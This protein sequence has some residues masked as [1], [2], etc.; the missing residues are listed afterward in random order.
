MK[1]IKILSMK[2]EVD[3]I[4]P[5]ANLMITHTLLQ[6]VFNE[7]NMSNSIIYYS[8]RSQIYNILKKMKLNMNDIVILHTGPLWK[9]F[10]YKRL[11]N[12]INS[13]FI[14]Y[15]SEPIHVR[16]W[17]WHKQILNHPK[18]LMIWDYQYLSI[19]N[20]KKQFNNCFFVPP[21]YDI[22]LENMIPKN[23]WNKK[24][25]DILFYGDLSS[26]RKKIRN[27]LKKKNLNIMF[28]KFTNWNTQCKYISR[29]K[30]VL[31]IHHQINYKCIDYYRINYLIANKVFII[32]EDVQKEE[33]N[34][35][36]YKKLVISK[37]ENI[38]DTC[39]EWL[40]KTQ[41]ERDVFSNGLYNFF[42][43]ELPLKNFIPKQLVELC[44]DN[45]IQK[46]PL[47]KFRS[48]QLVDIYPNQQKNI[49][50]YNIIPKPKKINIAN[51]YF[52]IS[53]NNKFIISI[54][55]IREFKDYLLEKINKF[56]E[57]DNIVENTIKLILEKDTSISNNHKIIIEK[58][59]ITINGNSRVAIFHG[60]QSFIQLFS[61]YNIP[62]GII[63]DNDSL[64]QW[65][66]MH[67]DICRHYYGKK[68][69]FDYI[70]KLALFKFN[71]F[72][73]HLTEDQGWRIEIK[74]YPLLNSIGSWRNGTLIG[75]SRK[76]NFKYDNIPHGGFLTKQDIRDIVEYANKNFIEII[77]EIDLPG[78]SL[79]AIASYPFLCCTGK[80]MDVC[81]RWGVIEDVL[82]A[83]NNDVYD[84]Y[85][86]ILDEVCELFPSKY[87]HIGGDECPKN[88]WKKCPNVNK[89]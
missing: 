84:F 68:Y 11:F 70:N 8:N 64:F 36:L 51:G 61:Q 72:H 23:R 50:N 74:K 73:L 78:H 49:L 48:K 31:V 89:K 66:T 46:I 53:N 42:K 58:N 27:E 15:N 10:N 56:C 57:T 44:F 83:G 55:S 85:F 45:K 25:I 88:R 71:K 80:K 63:E 33:Q 29:A 82:C 17:N 54:D 41:E 22:Y 77:P 12:N 5:Y 32:H 62:C 7:L 52:N 9:D 39:V 2:G 40:G 35:K 19:N 87:F 69:I 28:S 6:N 43:N 30:I 34:Q 75:R 16:N 76:S 14:I 47:K 86:N 13:E 1:T 59:C 81:C 3:T 4:G 37:Y 20:L 67:L 79:S 21:I 26:R 65:R 60:I 38:Y 24:N 18:L